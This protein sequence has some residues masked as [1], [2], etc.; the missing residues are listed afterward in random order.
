[1]WDFIIF[2]YLTKLL[3]ACLLRD[4]S[5]IIPRVIYSDIFVAWLASYD[6][7][8]FTQVSTNYH[9]IYCCLFRYLCSIV[10]YNVGFII[11]CVRLHPSHHWMYHLSTTSLALSHLLLHSKHQL[12]KQRWRKHWHQRQPIVALNS[13]QRRISSSASWRERHNEEQ[14]FG[15]RKQ[16]L[17]SRARRCW[18]PSDR[19]RIAHSPTFVE[20]CYRV[21]CERQWRK[22]AHRYLCRR[23]ELSSSCTRPCS[24]LRLLHSQC[25]YAPRVSFR[26]THHQQRRKSNEQRRLICNSQTSHALLK[27]SNAKTKIFTKYMYIADYMHYAYYIYMCICM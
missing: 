8:S 24:F 12:R 25:G 11:G 5:G 1:M 7:I 18:P 15:R 2:F 19:H 16:H 20:Y 4:L 17:S 9:S 22:G 23:M 3:C 13:C 27:A 6:I 21:D 14:I 26:N 10:Q